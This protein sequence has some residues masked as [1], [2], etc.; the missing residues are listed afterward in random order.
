M[1][2]APLV[3]WAWRHFGWEPILFYQRSNSS[4]DE[5]GEPNNLAYIEDL[6]DRNGI[7]FPKMVDS[8]EGYRSDTITQISRL[9]A[10]EVHGMN[11]DEYLMTGDIDMLPLSNYWAPRHDDITVYGHDLTGYGHYP[12]CYI[13]MTAVKWHA[14]MKCYDFNINEAGS[15]NKRQYN[16][17]IKRDLDT[18]PQA[19]DPDFYKYWFS[20][21]DLITQRLNEY[22]KEKIIFINRGHGT[23]GFARGRVDR[24]SGGWVLDQPELI[25]AHLI[26]QAHHEQERIQKILDLLVKVWPNEDWT[27]W[28]KYTEEFRR[29]TGH[30]G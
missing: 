22:G 30:T 13:G 28:L 1:F 27:W 20:D 5:K 23:H 12:I 18:L 7:S 21:Q 17:F 24:G 6:L 10:S 14:V 15:N 11:G 8:I 2:F 4:R 3:M 25:D 29:L 16:Y 19:K 26:Q 9:Y